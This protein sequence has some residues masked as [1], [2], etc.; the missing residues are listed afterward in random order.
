MLMLAFLMFGCG[1][2]KETT[3]NGPEDSGEQTIEDPVDTPTTNPDSI[4]PLC[5]TKSST[6]SY[7]DEITQVMDYTWDGLTQE[8]TDWYA[9]YND[10]GYVTKSNSSFDGYITNVIIS[11]ECDGWCKVQSTYYEDGTSPED[12]QTIE[13]QYN[14]EG[15]TQY[16][17]GHGWS[18]ESARY[19]KYNNM[20]YVVEYYDEGD[21]YNSQ[22]NYEYSCSD[23]WCKLEEITSLLQRDGEDPSETVTEYA[24]DGNR[25]TSD[26]GSTFY[27]DYGYVL[28]NDIVIGDSIT[29]QEYTYVCDGE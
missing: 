28:E 3:E 18:S 11:Y 15:N 17:V 29:R 21:G 10:Y 9:E 2:D 14:W 20:G 25:Q 6:S 5:L 24:W 1:P 19:W 23:T 4:R 16:Q 12:L 26:N 22:T 13:T 27:N 8:A 7:N